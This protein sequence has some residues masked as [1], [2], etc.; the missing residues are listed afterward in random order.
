MDVTDSET[1]KTDDGEVGVDEGCS[2]SGV[3]F[4]DSSVFSGDIRVFWGGSGL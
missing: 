2:D 1:V 4:C 3:C